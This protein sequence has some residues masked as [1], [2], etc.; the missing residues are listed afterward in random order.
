MLTNFV[1]LSGY[2]SGPA[3]ALGRIPFSL[4]NMLRG[5]GAIALLLHRTVDILKGEYKHE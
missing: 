1:S 3:M 4:V 5:L 2:S